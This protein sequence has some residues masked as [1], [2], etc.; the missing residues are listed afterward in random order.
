MLVASKEE[1][2]V[3]RFAMSPSEETATRIATLINDHD[4]EHLASAM[5]NELSQ[6]LKSETATQPAQ[7]SQPEKSSESIYEGE[8]VEHGAAPYK[9]KPD[10]AKPEGERNDSYY[11]T[12]RHADGSERTLWGVGL[13]DAVQQFNVGEKIKLEDKGVVPVKWTETLKDGSSVEKSGQRRTW[14]GSLV[15]RERDQ[16]DSVNYQN[17]EDYDGPGVA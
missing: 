13:E 15:G 1:G 7:T 3:F 12:L 5:R 4:P 11:V 6:E 10:M 16:N 2:E 9:F 14:E 8:L 17:H